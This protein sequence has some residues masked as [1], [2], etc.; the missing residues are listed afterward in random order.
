M[1][2][3]QGFSNYREYMQ[4]KKARFSYSLEDLARFCDAVVRWVV[5]VAVSRDKE[6]AKGLGQ[7]SLRPWDT[8]VGVEYAL[9]GLGALQLYAQAQ[10]GRGKAVAALKDVLTLGYSHPVA[11]LYAAAGLRFDLP[12]TAVRHAAELLERELS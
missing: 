6:R 1:A 3:G 11:E 10:A 9:A 8:R 5:P 7:P 4:R 2:R 12:E